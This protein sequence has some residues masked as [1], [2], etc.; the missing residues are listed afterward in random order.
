MARGDR[1]NDDVTTSRFGKFSSSE[2][3]ERRKGG[4]WV[5]GNRKKKRGE[6]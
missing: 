4:R 1:P 3:F 5:R 2:D 6:G